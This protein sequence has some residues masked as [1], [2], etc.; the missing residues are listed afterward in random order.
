MVY[1]EGL[2]TR[3]VKAEDDIE[4]YLTDKSQFAGGTILKKIVIPG[5]EQA[6]ALKQLSLMPITPVTLMSD[7]DGAAATAV[8]AVV[9]FGSD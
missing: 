7:A 4:S 1:Q 6:G 3:A 9:R 8:N 2:F 5:S